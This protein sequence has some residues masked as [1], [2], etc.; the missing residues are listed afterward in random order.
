LSCYSWF[1]EDHVEQIQP[2]PVGTCERRPHTP[3]C[4]SPLIVAGR[5]RTG[6]RFGRSGGC[7]RRLE[8]SDVAGAVDDVAAPGKTFALAV[9]GEPLP[10]T[11]KTLA[12]AVLGEPLLVTDKTLALA[13]LSEPLLVTGKA[14]ALAVLREPLPVTGKALALAVFS[15]PLLVTG[16]ALA[17][18]VL[19]EPLLVM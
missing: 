19:G 17:L 4:R 11:D 13:V 8:P 14:L 15:E 16:K 9:L 10:V 7:G 1:C 3:F 5:L 12:L 6:G 18:A 2:G